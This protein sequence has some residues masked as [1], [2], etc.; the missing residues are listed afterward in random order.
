MHL[1]RGS[2]LLELVLACAGPGA[3]SRGAADLRVREASLRMEEPEQGG[4][5]ESY[6]FQIHTAGQ[7]PLR[8][9]SEKQCAPAL[10][11]TRW[12]AHLH[13]CGCI[14][15]APTRHNVLPQAVQPG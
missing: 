9:L 7:Q 10:C 11:L 2:D 15:G 8:T 14:A 3:D 4:L 13:P 12:W 6:H 1:C 5:M